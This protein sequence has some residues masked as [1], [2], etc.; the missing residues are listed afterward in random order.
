MKEHYNEKLKSL[1][2]EKDT[3]KVYLNMINKFMD[4]EINIAKMTILPKVILHIQCNSNLNSI[5]LF[6][7]IEQNKQHQ[8]NC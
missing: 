3:G 1:K 7:E 8:Q 6:T 2:K 4:D 5:L